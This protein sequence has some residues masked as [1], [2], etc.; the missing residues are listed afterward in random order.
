MALDGT[1]GFSEMNTRALSASA[2]LMSGVLALA[3]GC[4]D[5]GRRQGAAGLGGVDDGEDDG[6]GA[7]GAD[8]DD[9]SDDGSD[10]EG[11]DGDD[12]PPSDFPEP[13]Q[14]E[15]EVPF[16]AA[17]LAE[18]CAR[19]N[20]DKVAQALC[21]GPQISSMTELVD[22]LGFEEPF[23][24]MTANS[25]SLVGRD[26][27]ALNPRLI[28]GEMMGANP[29]GGGQDFPG[30][31]NDPNK[32]MA[33]GFVRGEQLVE[34]MAYDPG[35]DALNFYLLMFEQGCNDTEEGCRVS[36]LVTPAI[37][38]NWSRWTIYQDTDLANTSLDCNVCHQ[39]LGVGTPK[40][41]RLQEISNSW[42][43]W[44]PTRPAQQGGGWSSGGSGT[45]GLPPQDPSTHGTRSS[46]VLWNLFESMHGDDPTYG[47]VPL[48]DIRNGAAGPDIETFVRS[49][50]T[51][52]A[53]QLPEAL[54]IPA[55]ASGQGND[56]FC[57]SSSME[58]LGADSDWSPQFERVVNGQRLPL[59]SHRI[60]ITSELAR[61]E[62]VETYKA[63][64]SGALPPED[65]VHPSAAI[66]YSSMAEMS[67]VPPQEAT[68]EQILTHMC[69]RC[70]NA[71]L[72]PTLS[73]AKFDATKLG[74]LDELQKAVIADRIQRHDDDKFQMP[75]RRSAT[76]PQWARTRVLQWLDQ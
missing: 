8:A 50:L 28:I 76:M 72:D 54:R 47:G 66:A 14:Q 56:Y 42:T 4:D 12:M 20:G 3:A 62:V 70:H 65:L 71:N 24:S 36:D 33:L 51:A 40:V 11:D 48:E 55:F 15:P 74:E 6:E 30:L 63:V 68:A 53:D 58:R 52:R 37:E 73:R 18:V 13:G 1:E 29:F 19:G 38:S 67:L 69:A 10:D 9:G 41:P 5:E 27:S 45:T 60:D 64:Q 35:T 25:S 59:P 7:E 31:D 44:F 17:K 16:D 23:F 22:T 57:D 75:P 46:E 32:V 21:D 26:V 34:L 61:D 39:P 49:W 43:H 2:F